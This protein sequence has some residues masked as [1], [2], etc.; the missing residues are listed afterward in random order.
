[1][2]QLDYSLHQHP[3][4]L[5]QRCGIEAWLHYGSVGS[6][7]FNDVL[8]SCLCQVN[9]HLIGSAKSTADD[10]CSPVIGQAWS[11]SPLSEL[12]P[13]PT[14]EKGLT[15]TSEDLASLNKMQ[16]LG[17]QSSLG[18]VTFNVRKQVRFWL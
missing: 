5:H 7:E 6:L 16:G 13:G 17:V 9:L 4:D 10:V 8:R 18:P 12:F 11:R 15:E 2:Q 1:M 3:G 14:W